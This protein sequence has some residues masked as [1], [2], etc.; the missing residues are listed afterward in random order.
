[1]NHYKSNLF[2]RFIPVSDKS[3]S[4]ISMGE[5]NTPV[6]R[7]GKELYAKVDYMMPTLSFKDRG[8]V[9]MI[10]AAH[11][12]GIRHIIQDSSGN[13]GCSVAAY[14]ARAGINADIYL[15]ESTPEKKIKMIESFGAKVLKIAGSRED[16]AAAAIKEASKGEKYYASHV[17]DPL[18]VQGMKSYLFEVYHDFEGDLPD[19][20]FV[21]LGNGTLFFG[22]HLALL[23]LLENQIINKSPNIIAIQTANC[24]PIYNSYI[25]WHAA[26][27]KHPKEK[28]K[29]RFHSVINRGTI[30]DGIAIASPAKGQQILETICNY[31][32]SI[33]AVDDT[34]ILD[35]HSALSRMGYYVEHTSAAN[36]AGYVKY[37]SKPDQVTGTSLI[38]LCG[39]TK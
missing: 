35:A 16:V 39:A 22:V 9:V 32:Y 21:P 38:T 27:Q 26:T 31:N 23:D 4:E 7:L 15:G 25:L 10:A 37:M 34:E 20:I 2:S 33:V 6:V 24:A 13:A 5:G 1:M 36:Y 17:F 19:N 12:K 8:A 3:I 28:V 18:F 29:P 30:A 14:C 11:E